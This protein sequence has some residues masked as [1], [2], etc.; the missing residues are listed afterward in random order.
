M[1]VVSNNVQGSSTPHNLF[2]TTVEQSNHYRLFVDNIVH[3]GYEIH[4]ILDALHNS[5]EQ[6]SLEARINS[7]GGAV[8]YGQQFINVIRDRFKGRSMTIIESEASSMAAILFMVGHHRVIYPHSILMVHDV[9]IQSH[10]K[11]SE[12]AKYMKVFMKTMFRYFEEIFRDYMTPKEIKI[13]FKG[14]DFWFNAKEMCR[15]G[16]ATHVIVDGETLTAE[17]Y[18]ILIKKP[19]KPK[20]IKK[21]KKASEEG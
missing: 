16:M 9:S 19:K 6:D 20:K 18:L 3:E 7:G 1:A 12:H 17:E 11:A 5:T 4:S 8:K 10:S 14:E 2:I 21:L 13:M 15:R